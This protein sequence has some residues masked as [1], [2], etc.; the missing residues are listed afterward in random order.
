MEGCSLAI[1]YDT[2][3]YPHSR[4]EAHRENRV[5]MWRDSYR[6]NIDCAKAIDAATREDWMG[7]RLKKDC[8]QKVL[9]DYGFKRVSYVLANTI[10]KAEWDGRYGKSNKAW[11]KSI[12]VPPDE[13]NGYFTLNAHPCIIENFVNQTRAAYQALN[14]F[15][16]EHCEQDSAELDYEGKVLI[17]SPDTLKEDCWNP[18]SQLWLAQ[19]GFGCDPNASGRKILATCLS[20]GETASWN[21][22]EFTGVIRDDQLPDWAQERLEQLQNPEQEQSSAGMGGMEMGMS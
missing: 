14:L 19:S 5:E 3:F 2:V 7:V 11:A 13:V 18:E 1:K 20:D 21:R 22:H 15:G 17:L 12:F 16:Q 9:A 4:E 6:A 8:A 10:Q